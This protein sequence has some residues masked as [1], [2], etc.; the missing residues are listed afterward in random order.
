MSFPTH[1]R[2]F[3]AK[4]TRKS[5][6]ICSFKYSRTLVIAP[7]GL[8]QSVKTCQMIDRSYNPSGPRDYE[9]RADNLDELRIVE[10][11]ERDLEL[12]VNILSIFSEQ[13]EEFEMDFEHFSNPKEAPIPKKQ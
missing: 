12:F 9:V 8:H 4:I 6:V 3:L 7:V 13:K 10:S 2:D 11:V 5:K 1:C